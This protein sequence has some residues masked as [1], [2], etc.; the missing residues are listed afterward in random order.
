MA[1]QDNNTGWVGWLYFASF[2]MI[3]LGA[4]QGIAGLAGIFHSSSYVVTQS[5]LLVFDTTTWGW[6]NLILGVVILIAGFELLRGA[7]WARIV[8]VFL[9]IASFV[10]N[11]AYFNAYPGWSIIM[12]VVDT[13]INYA[14]TVHG[15]EL[16]E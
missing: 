15:G 8:G 6:I 12:M 14:L 9:A 1:T 16:R 3:L 7:V 4:L 13:L 2:M 11:M 5:Q 10:A